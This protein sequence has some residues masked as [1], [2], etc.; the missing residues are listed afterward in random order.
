MT[1]QEINSRPLE[2]RYQLLSRLKMDCDY[3]LGNGLCNKKYLWAG[4]EKEQIT[5][6]KGIFEELPDVP[7]WI[8]FLD[9]L[10]YEWYM[11]RG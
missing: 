9:I 3:Y 6:M 1:L 2:F 7:E 5:I 8:S 4:D 10:E 11:V